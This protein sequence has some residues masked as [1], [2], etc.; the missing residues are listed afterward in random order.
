MPP[1]FIESLLRRVPPKANLN[2]IDL[3]S[4]FR[5]HDLTTR[6]EYYY[7]I[8]LNRVLDRI[9]IAFF[10]SLATGASRE[11]GERHTGVEPERGEPEEQLSRADGITAR[12]R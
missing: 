5:S 1:K 9:S 7:F 10:F 2:K 8:F 12:A 6:S 3:I 4:Y 11:N